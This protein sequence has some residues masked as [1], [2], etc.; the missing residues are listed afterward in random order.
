M[1]Q[2]LLLAFA[3][4][5]VVGGLLGLLAG[6][7]RRGA[8]PRRLDAD[9]L[10]PVTLA[11][12]L[13]P[14]EAN[15]DAM[16]RSL[17]SRCASR[18]QLPCALAM[19]E[20]EGGA[21]VIIAISEGLDPRL[22]NAPVDMIGPAGNAIMEGVPIVGNADEPLIEALRKDR[23]RPINGGVVVPVGQPQPCGVVLAF[24]IPDSMADAVH[25][26]TAIVRMHETPLALAHQ[27]WLAQRRADTDDLTGLP[28]RRAL[29]GAQARDRGTGQP[30]AVREPAALIALDID[31]FKAINDNH[32]HAAGDAALRQIARLLRETVRSGD[33]AARVGGEEFALW[34]PGATLEAAME[35]AERLR[36][37]VEREPFRWQGQELRLTI[38]CGVAAF[39]SPVPVAD[40]LMET[41]D[42]ALYQAKHAGRNQVMPA[43][44]SRQAARS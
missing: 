24:G 20:R 12:S 11:D 33:V 19:R 21:P 23:R 39:P 18:A 25:G 31:H 6:R 16:A 42:A 4:G 44:E 9:T 13:F 34:L 37:R 5:V 15:F 38:S 1:T 35:I 29:L 40:N 8:A 17:A 28:N 22:M 36:A 30:T 3:A 27:V 41:A 7:L 43:R 2:L 14:A 26:M 32:G 10:A